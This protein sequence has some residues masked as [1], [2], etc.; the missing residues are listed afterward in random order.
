MTNMCVNISGNVE[1]LSI[2]LPKPTVDAKGCVETD[3]PNDEER[4]FCTE[5]AEPDF[6]C[7]GQADE[8]VGPSATVTMNGCVTAFGLG[9]DTH[10]LT[11]SVFRAETMDG[12]LIDPGYDLEGMAGA[13]ADNTP[14]AL[15]GR[16]VSTKVDASECEDEG[17][18]EVEGIP[19]ETELVVRVTHQNLD[20]DSREFVD[21][22]QYNVRLSNGSI[23]DSMG[24]DVTDTSSCDSSSCFVDETVNTITITTFLVIPP[25]ARV[26]SILGSEDLFDGFGQGHIAGEVQDCSSEDTVQNAVVGIDGKAKQRT[27]FNVGLPPDRD[28]LA[29]PKAEVTRTMTNA[30][31]LFAFLAVDTESG[32][33][34]TE[35]G[36]AVLPSV[37]GED[38]ICECTEAGEKNPAWTAA[39]A[40][41]GEVKVLGSRAV[42]VFP[43]S[44]TLMSFDRSMYVSR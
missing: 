20:K 39:D 10:G 9:G 34:Q 12:Q 40:G 24:N 21:T 37:C 11:V 1:G 33:T 3:D 2:T 32:A 17:A 26:S 27:Y 36:A 8:F 38:G 42:Y 7:L 43:D 29:D 44:I 18:F 22:Y 4:S 41:E 6:S 23:I 31:G 13:Q 25:T 35:I 14:S 19:T 16:T 28:N 5:K 15:L 30:D